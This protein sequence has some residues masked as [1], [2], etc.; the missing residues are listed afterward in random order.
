MLKCLHEKNRRKGYER[1]EK[2]RCGDVAKLS[3]FTLLR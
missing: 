1:R 2:W 3:K